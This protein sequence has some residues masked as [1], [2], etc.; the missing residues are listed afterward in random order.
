MKALAAFV[1]GITVA[2]SAAAQ[3]AVRMRQPDDSAGARRAADQR[4]QIG[5]MERVLEGAVEHGVTVTKDRLQALAQMPAEMLVSD[6]AHARGFRLEGYGVFFDVVVPSFE[7][8]LTWTLRTLDQND[9][10]LDSAWRALRT[11]VKTSGDPNLEQALKR[12][13]LQVNPAV[14]ARATVPEI[15][16]AR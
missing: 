15:P 14:Q 9:L 6:N 3:T 10:G 1:I 2:T 8:T 12:I 13:E 5:Q 11:H 7:T 16:D 4:Y